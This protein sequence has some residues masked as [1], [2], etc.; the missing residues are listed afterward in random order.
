MISSRFALDTSSSDLYLI[1][2]TGVLD[3]VAATRLL[4]LVDARLQVLESGH[5]RTRHIVVD[6]S[7]TPTAT[8]TGLAILRHAPYAANRRGVG[9]YLSGV[10]ALTTTAPLD[11]RRH[12]CSFASY[13]SVAAARIALVP[14]AAPEPDFPATDASPAAAFLEKA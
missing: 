2:V 11:A 6:L 4:R 12:L 10:E 5:A 9:F 1:S 3:N 14:S 8:A 13:S 7:R